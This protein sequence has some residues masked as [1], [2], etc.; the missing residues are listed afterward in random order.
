MS[1]D[2]EIAS[3]NS[4]SCDLQLRYPL[5]LFV[6]GPGDLNLP[7]VGLVVY[8]VL[9]LQAVLFLYIQLYNS[10]DN[11]LFLNETTYLGHVT[12]LDVLPLLYNSTSSLKTARM[13]IVGSA[14]LKVL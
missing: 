10:T 14:C 3:G 8:N 12:A 13:S 9:Y 1:R 4:A 5:L 11:M 2:A 7:P 6:P